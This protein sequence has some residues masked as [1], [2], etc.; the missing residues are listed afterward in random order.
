MSRNPR[1]IVE[2]GLFCSWTPDSAKLFR[3]SLLRTSDSVR[4]RWSLETK[5]IE[6]PITMQPGSVIILTTR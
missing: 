1:A 5:T 6:E 2:L 4:A 3:S